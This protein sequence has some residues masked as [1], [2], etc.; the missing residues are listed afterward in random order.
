MYGDI[1]KDTTT[2]KQ[3][4]GKEKRPVMKID[5]QKIKSKSK[6]LNEIMNKKRK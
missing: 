3:R 1:G 4:L 6:H 5:E 2:R